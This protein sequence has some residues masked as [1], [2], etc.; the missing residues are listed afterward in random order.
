MYVDC[1]IHDQSGCNGIHGYTSHLNSKYIVCGG[2]FINLLDLRVLF[3]RGFAHYRSTV[4]EGSDDRVYA[5]IHG[6][7]IMC[8][9]ADDLDST[10]PTALTTVHRA[11][12]DDRDRNFHIL[13]SSTIREHNSTNQ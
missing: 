10:C 12:T 8:R 5:H 11:L 9:Y 6:S 13:L 4:E 2:I 3:H 7:T 1:T